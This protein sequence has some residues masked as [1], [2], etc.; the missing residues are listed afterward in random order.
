VPAPGVTG[1][2]AEEW[3]AGEAGGLL[4]GENRAEQSRAGTSDLA[5]AQGS[6]VERGGL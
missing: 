6:G 2:I 5:S 1:G 4:R 3:V